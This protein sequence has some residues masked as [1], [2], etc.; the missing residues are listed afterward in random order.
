MSLSKQKVWHFVTIAANCEYVKIDACPANHFFRF[1][2]GLKYYNM[3][4]YGNILTLFDSNEDREQTVLTAINKHG[5]KFQ[6]CENVFFIETL[7]KQN[8]KYL[9]EDLA[10]KDL[11]FTFYHNSIPTGS[12]VRS[13]GIDDAILDHIDNILF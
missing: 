2:T 3:S 8:T 11:I 4:Y 13:K 7:S 9:I 1:S 12:Y 5:L 6:Q 10:T